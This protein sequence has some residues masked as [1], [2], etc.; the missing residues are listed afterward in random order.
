[1]NLAAH[2]RG[3]SHRVVDQIAQQDLQQ[4]RLD[5]NDRGCRRRDGQR[6]TALQRGLRVDRGHIPGHRREV[7]GPIRTSGSHRIEPCQREQLVDQMRGAIAA[8][9]YALKRVSSLTRVGCGE[10]NLG[11]R[12]Q[13]GNGRAQFVRRIGRET[14]LV[15]HR[16]AHALEQR[17][18]AGDERG[19]V[20][21]N[22]A[23][24]ERGEVPRIA[25]RDGTADCAQGT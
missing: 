11:L 21:R 4:R 13:R 18:E 5:G 6:Q 19:N 15:F 23:L 17:V 8:R 24:V 3:I 14:A 9:D 22:R 12:P 16:C 25:L 2:A 10:G 1:M 20:T 7:G